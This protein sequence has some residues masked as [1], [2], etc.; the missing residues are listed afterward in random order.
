MQ[1]MD[2]LK[3]LMGGE[4]APQAMAEEAAG[5]TGIDPS[6]IMQFLPAMAAMMQ[7]G[8]QRNVPDAEIATMEGKNVGSLL[9]GLLNGG[10]GGPD[11]GSLGK[12]LDADG[13]GSPL[14]D[15]MGRF[16]R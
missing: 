2:F 5:R 13:D 14:D 7:G 12:L 6:I 1:G 16:L 9:G 10:G 3:T 8:M 11:L 15:I 4:Q